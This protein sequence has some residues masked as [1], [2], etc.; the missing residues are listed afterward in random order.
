[1]TTPS[2]AV[3]G[4]SSSLT[5]PPDG[6]QTHPRGLYPS[7]FSATPAVRKPRPFPQPSRDTPTVPTGTSP[8]TRPRKSL[9]RA[10]TGLCAPIGGG[11]VFFFIIVAFSLRL[12]SIQ[13]MAA[14]LQDGLEVH[15]GNDLLHLV[16][17]HVVARLE[18]DLRELD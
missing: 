3:V 2:P 6:F 14:N 16:Q 11:W 12:G 10:L 4:T 1:M 9:S 7:L 15:S 18:N 8:K 13:R 5:P 17:G